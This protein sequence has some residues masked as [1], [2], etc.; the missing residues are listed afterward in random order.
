[1]SKSLSGTSV[2]SE[3][4]F[5]QSASLSSSAKKSWPQNSES[6]SS[7]SNACVESQW[8]NNAWKDYRGLL[9]PKT[10]R[11]TL[12]DH[13]EAYELGGQVREVHMLRFQSGLDHHV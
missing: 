4:D 9:Y 12:D 2:A 13:F 1:M 5:S 3:P 10:N 8:I 11:L 6:A 7:S